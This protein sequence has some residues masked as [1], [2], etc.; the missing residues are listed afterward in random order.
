MA[1]EEV[2]LNAGFGSSR[3]IGVAIRCKINGWVTM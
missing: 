3:V 1:A 2:G